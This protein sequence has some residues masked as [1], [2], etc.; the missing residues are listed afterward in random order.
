MIII[1]IIP[2]KWLQLGYRDT[3]FSDKPTWSTHKIHDFWW[4]PGPHICAVQVLIA[5]DVISRGIDV[6]QVRGLAGPGVRTW[7][8]EIPQMGLSENVGYIPNEIAI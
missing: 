6:P 4:A 2:I 3:L 7:T 8:F 1:L 5:T